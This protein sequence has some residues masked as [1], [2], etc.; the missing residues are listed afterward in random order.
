MLAYDGAT[1]YVDDGGKAFH[2]MSIT[3]KRKVHLHVY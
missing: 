1:L 3:H 2:Y